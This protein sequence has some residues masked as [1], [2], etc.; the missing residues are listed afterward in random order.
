MEKTKPLSERDAQ[1]IWHPYTQTQTAEAPIA[2]TKAKGAYLYAEDGTPYLDGIS[3]WWVNLHGHSHPHIA[4]RIALQAMQLE[5]VMFAGFTHA[6]AIELGEKLT[7]LTGMDKIFYSDNGSTAVETALK[8]A[9]QFGHNTSP[10][11]K[12]KKFLSFKNS[13]HGETFGAMSVS[14]KSIF[15]EPFWDHLFP[16][17]NL[18]LPLHGQE[19]KFL[20]SLKKTLDSHEIAAFIFEPLILG[21]GG[22]KIYSS[23]ALSEAIKLCREMNVLT[24]AD[25][26]MTGFGRTGPLF[27][28]D[29][30]EE[31]PDM[32]CL[33]KG[34]TGGFLPLGATLC[35]QK[36]FDAF[37]SP[38]YSK[39]FLHGHSYTANPL[40]C[41]AG[42]ASL[43]L[44]LTKE[45]HAKREMIAHA[46]KAFC[47]KFQSHPSLLRCES[48]GTILILE[49]RSREP[50]GYLN[51]IKERLYRYFIQQKI[52]LRP[53]GNTVHVIPPYCVTEEELVHIYAHLANTFEELP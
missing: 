2:I 14:G 47:K 9:L 43:E 42:L 35:N 25:E 13:F 4:N 22:M 41:A 45:C 24:I 11:S 46:H 21:A 3:S 17:E 51:P 29:L 16:S 20:A 27:A 31:K 7:A 32:V 36:I 26:V 37:L 8:M 28:C 44:L 34:I 15:N 48:L 1:V 5:H 33:S 40:A 12:R 38:S 52:L 19:E 23:Q 39:A 30:L 6:G 18:D 53:F 49:Y 10:H 50:S